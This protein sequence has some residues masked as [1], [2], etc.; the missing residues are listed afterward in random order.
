[1]LGMPCLGRISFR[2]Q[3]LLHSEISQQTRPKQSAPTILPTPVA[4]V[5]ACG[6]EPVG[7]NKSAD[8]GR[9]DQAFGTN[10]SADAGPLTGAVRTNKCSQSGVRLT[11]LGISG[12]R[13]LSV[14]GAI[15]VLPR[16]VASTEAVG[17]GKYSRHPLLRYA[18][19]TEQVARGYAA[20][21]GFRRTSCQRRLS[22]RR[23]SGFVQEKT[24]AIAVSTG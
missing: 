16:P 18:T 4:R 15:H 11:E 12:Q 22:T 7:I 9:L 8:A 17:T 20:T 24:S 14:G 19:V 1:M 21:V 3:I 6:C 2:S 13:R 10:K 5:P 23:T